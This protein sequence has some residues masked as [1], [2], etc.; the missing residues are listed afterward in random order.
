MFAFDG[1]CKIASLYYAHLGPYMDALFGL[2]TTSVGKEEAIAVRA[3]EFWN[4]IC[5]VEIAIFNGQIETVSQEY[6]KK[7]LHVLVPLVTSCMTK[8]VSLWVSSSRV[9]NAATTPPSRVTFALLLLLCFSF[10]T[11]YQTEDYDDDTF[12]LAMAGTT[13]LGLIAQ[14]CECVATVPCVQAR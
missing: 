13:C 14:V 3:I 10:E 11:G 9:K 8:Q 5:E 12:T 1:I 7:A 2:T 4:V 6:V